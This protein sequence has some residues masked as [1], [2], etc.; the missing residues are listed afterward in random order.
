[1]GLLCTWFQVPGEYT[2][3]TTDGARGSKRRAYSA[4]SFAS[5]ASTRMELPRVRG[6]QETGVHSDSALN[7]A[8]RWVYF[9]FLRIGANGPMGTGVY[10]EIEKYTRTLFHSVRVP[11]W[12]A[13]VL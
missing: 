8:C 6:G 2:P 12:D 3:G 5:Q 11:A 9:M 1:M 7:S 4:T 10:R 13:K